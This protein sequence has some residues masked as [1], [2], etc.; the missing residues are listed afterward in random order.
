MASVIIVDDS[1]VNRKLLRNIL[2]SEG[3]E[4]VGDASNGKEGYD[5]F[6]SKMPDVVTLDVSMPE[7]NGIEALKLM[8]KHNP[9]AKVIILSASSEQEQRDEAAQHGADEFVSKPYQKKDILE[10]MKRCTEM[11]A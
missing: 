7:M 2:E 6:V 5:V 9:S 1:E 11:D 10:A 3:Y 4:V 8:K